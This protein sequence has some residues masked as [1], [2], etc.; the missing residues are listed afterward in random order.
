MN[1][2]CWSNLHQAFNKNKWVASHGQLPW[3]QKE[4]ISIDSTKNANIFFSRSTWLSTFP[5]L[6]H[7][8]PCSIACLAYIRVCLFRFGVET[9]IFTRGESCQLEAYKINCQ[10]LRKFV[11]PLSPP[12]FFPN[13]K[14][15]YELNL[16]CMYRV[17]R[18]KNKRVLDIYHWI[19]MWRVYIPRPHH[20]CY[21]HIT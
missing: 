15:T 20:L 13:T 8:E 7:C 6:N 4:N 12:H 5:V 3:I 18:H 9:S 14:I 10:Q 17:R 11:I 16:I 1:T 2:F 19:S 21:A